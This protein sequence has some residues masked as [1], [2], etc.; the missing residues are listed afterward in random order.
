MSQFSK[1][2]YGMDKLNRR[3]FRGVGYPHFHAERNKHDLR[4]VCGYDVGETCVRVSTMWPSIEA[5]R[6][7]VR[8]E[9]TVGDGDSCGRL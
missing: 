5:R 2:L 6:D 9:I 8:P 1:V 7:G 4:W 3:L